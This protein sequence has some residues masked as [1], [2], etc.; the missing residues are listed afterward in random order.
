MSN[1]VQPPDVWRHVL[2]CVLED[3]AVNAAGAFRFIIGHKSTQ[4]LDSDLLSSGGRVDWWRVEH[5]TT[6]AAVTTGFFA[7]ANGIVTAL[8]AFGGVTLAQRRQSD[9]DKKADERKLRDNSR[10]RLR[11]ASKLL[12]E[13]VWKMHQI[14]HEYDPNKLPLD[15]EY[16]KEFWERAEALVAE[17][18]Q[19]RAE[20]AVDVDDHDVI[21]TSREM[22]AILNAYEKMAAEA[23][24]SGKHQDIQ[25][26]REQAGRVQ[27]KMI[28]TVKVALKKYE[29]PI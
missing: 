25:A 12:L 13:T 19:T 17:M 8:V 16:R 11:S 28:E 27:T 5:P 23:L 6:I 7:V 1:R 21:A 14:I 18:E 22:R 9:R 4:T 26:V 3:K 10:E 24:N 2:P 15:E 29:L 20:V